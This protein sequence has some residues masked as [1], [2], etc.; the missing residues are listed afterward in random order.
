MQLSMR[1][2][3]L[4]LIMIFNLLIKKNHNLFKGVQQR[5]VKLHSL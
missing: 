1:L 3:N 5:F 2:E 4:N